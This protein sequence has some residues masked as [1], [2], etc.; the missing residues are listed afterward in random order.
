MKLTK[1][2]GLAAL[3]AVSV[4]SAVA[5]TSCAQEE[6]LHGEYEETFGK[7]QDL[8]VTKVDVTVK[9][10]KI[11]SVVMSAD[12]N[13]YTHESSRWPESSWTDYE[14]EVLK[15]FEGQSV[16]AILAAE[17]NAVFEPISGATVTSNRI[18][19]AVLNALKGE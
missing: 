10:D 13:H 17:E 19:Q 1:K 12:S 11:V 7:N 4:F 15:A 8:Y 3:A 18:Y 2:L 9:G 14:A 6:V 16:S 5:L